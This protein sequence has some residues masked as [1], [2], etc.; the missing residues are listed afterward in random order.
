MCEI[1]ILDHELLMIFPFSEIVRIVLQY[2]FDQLQSHGQYKLTC[3][4]AVS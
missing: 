2:L 4:A 1:G 3:N